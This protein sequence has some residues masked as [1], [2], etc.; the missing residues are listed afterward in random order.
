MALLVPNVGEVRLLEWAINAET[1]QNLTL[2]LYTNDETP[3]ED[4]EADDF[5]ACGTAGYSA[6]TLTKGLFTVGTV[7]GTTSATYAQQTI[8]FTASGTSIKGYFVV[9]ANDDTLIWAEKFAA[10]EPA[11]SGKKLY[12]TPVITLA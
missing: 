3:D 11:Y 2:E 12:I 5:T 10:A 7:G 8:T 6:M 1:Q 9:D 4:S